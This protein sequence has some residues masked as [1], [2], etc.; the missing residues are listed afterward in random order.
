MTGAVRS[1]P[2]IALMLVVA[3]IAAAA[4][5]AAVFFVVRGAADGAGRVDAAGADAAM[6]ASRT[7]D[8]VSDART[9]TVDV[10]SSAA[11]APDA[12]GSAASTPDARPATAGAA[13]RPR[14]DAHVRRPRPDARAIE[15]RPEP[16]RPPGELRVN[17]I[18]Y[19]EVAIDGAPRG[20]TPIRL[21]VPAG[22]H[23]VSLHNPD[24]G[25]RKTIVVLVPSGGKTSITSW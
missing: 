6:S 25:Q 20:R 11:S 17:L 16:A 18:P 23:K 15:R 5:G 1:K 14:P 8:A 13:H 24:T 12:A 9:A 4:V 2:R 3:L 7:P 21:S 19:A 10:G 22:R